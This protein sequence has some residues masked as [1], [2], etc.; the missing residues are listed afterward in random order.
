MT[1]PQIQPPR[2]ASGAQ[3]APDGYQ[4]TIG[5]ARYLRDAKGR[6]T[7][8]A[9]VRPQDMLQDEMV[10]KILKFAGALS[11]Q[12]A[13]FRG[14]VFDDI[15][16]FDA[17]LAAEYGGHARRSVKGNRT[18]QSYDGCLKVQV[19]VADRLAFGPEL[20]I[21]RDLIEECLSEWAE[22]SRDEI[23]ALVSHAFNVDKSG[24]ISRT[25]IYSL[26]RLEIDDERWRRGM[27]AVRDAMRIVGSKTY[28][29]CY[30]RANPEAAWEPVTID[31]AKV[32][33]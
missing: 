31:L 8:E 11:A 15:G 14:H 30:R 12:I 32:E 9:L 21:A 4:I 6:L 22:G 7:P 17:L 23:R 2:D 16:A 10:R 1:Q 19:Q 20:Q 3:A 24:E 33:A 13:R 26:L 25:A 29:R 18:Y 28:V 5:G 27:K